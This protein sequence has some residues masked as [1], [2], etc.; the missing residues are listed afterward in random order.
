M[1]IER[2]EHEV[3]AAQDRLAA[4]ESANAEL[5][6]D[7]AATLGS[8]QHARTELDVQ[9]HERD[10]AVRSMLADVQSLYPAIEYVFAATGCEAVF[11]AAAA[12]AAA[13]GG[14]AEVAAHDALSRAVASPLRSRLPA[15]RMLASPTVQEEV[16][17]AVTTATLARFLGVIEN[18]SADVVQQYA[19]RCAAA[20]PSHIRSAEAQAGSQPS[21]SSSRRSSAAQ[22]AHAAA[23]IGAAAMAEA[24]ASDSGVNNSVPASALGPARPTGRL[25]ETLTSAAVVAALSMDPAKMEVD[26]A[27]AAAAAAGT[28]ASKRQQTDA[29]PASRK[30]H[31]A[32]TTVASEREDDGSVRPVPLA[33]LKR[34]AM[35][36]MAGD[37]MLR[38]MRASAGMAATVMT[39]G[40]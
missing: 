40:Q 36:Q 11:D 5:K 6:A 35:T 16:R 27:A 2:L 1:E 20:R 17:G 31:R 9:L 30:G 26:E 15:M 8:L 22:L 28:G 19:V 10:A 14:G 25:R 3:R 34:Q 24:H 18:R 38:A 13:G 33:E 29:G 37:K 21:Q 7:R 39:R 12:A 32:A 23:S 4:S